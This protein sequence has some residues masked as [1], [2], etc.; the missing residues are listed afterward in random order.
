MNL[1]EFSLLA[2]WFRKRAQMLML[3]AAYLARMMAIDR[4]LPSLHFHMIEM[5]LF[6]DG[7]AS[8]TPSVSK[9]W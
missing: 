3:T 2:V 7:C 4:T 8:R 9:T 1:F 6:W 5:V